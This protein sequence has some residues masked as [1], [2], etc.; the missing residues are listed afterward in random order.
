MR[1]LSATG[2]RFVRVDVVLANS[3]ER[4]EKLKYL[5]HDAFSAGER[6]SG[7]RQSNA[8]DGRTRAAIPSPEF[9]LG[10]ETIRPRGFRKQLSP[11]FGLCSA[12]VRFLSLQCA[13]ILLIP[14]ARRFPLFLPSQD[15]AS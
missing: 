2:L 8:Q 11:F 3:G 10:Y 1:W 7:H 4:R 13:L 15:S 9:V 6:E 5:T 14:L 12:S